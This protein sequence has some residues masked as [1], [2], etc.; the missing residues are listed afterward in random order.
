MW[1]EMD[2]GAIKHVA[3]VVTQCSSMRR[4]QND[5]SVCKIEVEHRTQKDHEWVATELKYFECKS[6]DQKVEHVFAVPIKA[7][8]VRIHIKKCTGGVCMCAGVLERPRTKMQGKIVSV[9]SSQLEEGRY[10]V[11]FAPGVKWEVDV[12]KT[13]TGTEIGYSKLVA[14]LRHKVEFSKV[15]TKQRWKSSTYQS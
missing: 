6:G 3:G 7:Q 11:A 5:Q 1:M 4:I 10:L 14:A 8:Y 12:E 15:T 9:K 13:Q 2:L